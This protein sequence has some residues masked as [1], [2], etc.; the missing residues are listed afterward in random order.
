MPTNA[1]AGTEAGAGRKR[2]GWARLSSPNEAHRWLQTGF[3][4]LVVELGEDKLRGGEVRAVGVRPDELARRGAPLVELEGLGA[5]LGKLALAGMV[6]LEAHGA[7]LPQVPLDA[8][9]RSLA[10]P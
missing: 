8:V 2:R 4:S 6:E 9:D 10:E 3:Q 5:C 7:A 1:A